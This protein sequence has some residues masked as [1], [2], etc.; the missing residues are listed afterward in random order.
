MA[1]VV[2]VFVKC[3]SHRARDR[4]TRLM[5]GQPMQCYWSWHHPAK[6]GY[7]LIPESKLAEARKIPGVTR[8]SHQDDL[9]LCWN[10]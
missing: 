1:D 7:F 6:G 2:G 5:G 8:S 4:L 10:A 9:A 3:A